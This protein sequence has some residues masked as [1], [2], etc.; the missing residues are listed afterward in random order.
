M[1]YEML[2]REVIAEN[3]ERCKDTLEAIEKCESVLKR[4]STSTRWE[5]YQKKWISYNELIEYTNKRIR[6]KYKKKLQEKME[7]IA[8]C[9]KAEMPGTISILVE[10]KKSSVWGY[11]PHAT[12]EIGNARFTG[13]ASG[14][15]YD[16]ESAAGDAALNQSYKMQKILFEMKETALQAGAKSDNHNIIGHGAGYSATPYFEGGVGMSCFINILQKAGYK[17]NYTGNSNIDSY[18]FYK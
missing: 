14:C 18:F 4:E 8:S 15:G 13:Y 12:V 3:E 2:K 6:R 11:N 1:V 10:W 7:T 9:E 17:Y 16:K 5:Q